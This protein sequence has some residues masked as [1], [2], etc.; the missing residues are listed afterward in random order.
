MGNLKLRLEKYTNKNHNTMLNKAA[1]AF[2]KLYS[3][4]KA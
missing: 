2:A 3:I 1:I 4:E